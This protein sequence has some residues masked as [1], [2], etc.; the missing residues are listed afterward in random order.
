VEAVVEALVEAVVEAVV[1][2]LVE[3]L[4]LLGGGGRGLV[5][6]Q[7]SGIVYGRCNIQAGRYNVVIFERR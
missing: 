5:V 6:E 3:L 7:Y 4:V 1:E 2:A